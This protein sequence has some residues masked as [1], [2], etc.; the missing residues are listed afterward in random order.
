MP[1]TTGH[2]LITNPSSLYQIIGSSH[3]PRIILIHGFLGSIDDWSFVTQ[4]LGDDY[5][6]VLVSLPGHGNNNTDCPT[7]DEFSTIIQDIAR[8]KPAHLIAYSMGARLGLSAVLKDP[9]LWHQVIL[10]SVNPGLTPIDAH[11]R[12]IRDTELSQSIIHD[13]PSFLNT[14]YQAPLW[15][16]IQSH[17]HFKSRLQTQSM[18]HPESIS[19]VL[20]QFSVANI[21]HIPLPLSQ[22]ERPIHLISGSKDVK[23]E[24]ILSSL[25][26]QSPTLPT[27]L[28]KAL[29]IIL[30]LKT[31]KH[32]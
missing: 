6:L 5:E 10:E 18:Y 8:S 7:F 20:T 31:L 29:L 30:T 24:Q 32:F 17:P 11:T 1:L 13:Y 2:P 27:I 3:L 12:F 15:G 25:S 19:K 21:L 4:S 23:Y 14:W 16:D 28:S 26:H 22:L 9:T